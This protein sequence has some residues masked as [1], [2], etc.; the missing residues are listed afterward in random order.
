MPSQS[1]R[2]HP[3]KTPELWKTKKD[4]YYQSDVE[5]RWR[6]S[7]K[8]ICYGRASRRTYGNIGRM[9]KK[10]NLR[11][12]AISADVSLLF[13]FT[14]L[15]CLH[16]H[17]FIGSGQCRKRKLTVQNCLFNANVFTLICTETE[18]GLVSLDWLRHP[19]MWG[20]CANGSQVILPC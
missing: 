15:L 10:K 4:N 6:R 2:H 8:S 17:R 16:L 1:K 19:A 12:V 18:L 7:E 3:V 11:F 5:R 9:F 20:L 14:D 13:V